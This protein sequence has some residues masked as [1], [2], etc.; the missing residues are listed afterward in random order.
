MHI[1]VSLLIS[2]KHPRRERRGSSAM[3]VYLLPSNMS[4]CAQNRSQRST[5]GYV[6]VYTGVY[7]DLAN[8]ETRGTGTGLSGRLL[9]SLWSDPAN[10]EGIASRACPS[11]FCLSYHN[12]V[13][14]FGKSLS[15]VRWCEVGIVE[16]ALRV[17]LSYDSI[18][19]FS[20]SVGYPSDGFPISRL[21]CLDLL[22]GNRTLPGHP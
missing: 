16:Q 18:R 8:I 21:D 11:T 14:A 4:I 15:I 12:A 6:S 5:S 9:A 1:T 19:A 13:G 10:S 20:I 2:L 7:A 3:R 22:I 17:I